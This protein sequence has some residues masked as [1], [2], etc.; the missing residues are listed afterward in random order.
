MQSSLTAAQAEAAAYAEMIR[1]GKELERAVEA[2]SAA[3]EE[4]RQYAQFM[5]M[6]EQRKQQSIEYVERHRDAALG[7]LTDMYQR[8]GITPS[9]ELLRSLGEQPTPDGAVT[10]AAM[11]EMVE[12]VA[13]AAMVHSVAEREEEFQKER[14]ALQAEIAAERARSDERL[15]MLKVAGLAGTFEGA[16][17][18]R[19]AAQ[20]FYAQG[21]AASPAPAAFFGRTPGTG[22]PLAAGAAAAPAAP[23]AAV[24]DSAAAPSA[25]AP[26]P[27]VTYAE[28][29]WR[30]VDQDVVAM[31]RAAGAGGAIT[32]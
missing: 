22:L 24:A 32:G 19:T 13:G 28:E 18:A 12:T 23:A 6:L 15:Q 3:P 10:Q 4:A 26:S 14:D 11:L 2:K 9:P 31:L 27:P 20:A 8:A 17:R 16:K 29:A 30:R 25:A 7:K 1:M 5:A 21:A